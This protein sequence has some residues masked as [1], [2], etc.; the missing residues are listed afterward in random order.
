M[1]MTSDPAAPGMH[2]S[3]SLPP[4]IRTGQRVDLREHQ[5]ANR[6]AFIRW[7]GDPEI[8]ELLRHDL[9][10]L[11]PVRAKAYFD[12]IILPQSARGTCWAIH[13]HETGRLIGM[14][15]VTDI[16]HD[17]SCLFRIVIGEKDTWDRGMGTEATRLVADIVARDL[18]LRSMTLEVFA[19]NT[20]AQR[21]YYR[22]GFRER[23][24]HSEWVAQQQRRLDVIEMDL[25]L[26]EFME[27]HSR[28]A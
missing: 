3:S 18:G 1:T 13:E 4:L 9:T 28:E 8:A 7:Y 15:A 11:P 5:V 12:T 24:R 17:G 25:D 16:R 14:T 27:H 23:G 10:P 20:R 19:Y 22:V 21:A 6:D 26:T 2:D